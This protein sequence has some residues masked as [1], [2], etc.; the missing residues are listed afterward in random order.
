MPAD[1][2]RLAGE[3]RAFLICSVRGASPETLAAQEQYVRDLEAQGFRVHYPP[4]DTDQ[5]AP[6]LE[7]CRQNARAIAASDVVHVW[8]APDS[9]GSHFDM[10]VAFA[11]SKRIVIAH[12]VPYGPGKSYP[13]MLAE[14]EAECE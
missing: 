10:G 1:L 2:E 5:T 11:L 6:G 3:Q 9:Q 8:Y 14:W 12:S 4:R 13:R 7:I